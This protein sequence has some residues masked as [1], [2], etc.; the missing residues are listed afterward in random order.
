MKNFKDSSIYHILAVSGTHVGYIIIGLTYLLNRKNGSKR[1]IKAITAIFLII[2][3]AIS[4]FTASVVRACI[5]SIMLLL[6][7]IVYRKNDIW[8]SMCFSLLIILIS[9]PYNIRNNGVLLS[10]GGTIGIVYFLNN[11]KESKTLTS[12]T[13]KEKVIRYIKNT[14]LVSFSAQIILIPIIIYNYKTISLTF[15]ITNILTSY[16]IGIIIIFGFLLII[17]SF[18]FLKIA[19]I[20]GNIYKPIIDLLEFI[21]KNTAKLPFS[22]IYIKLPYIWEIIIYYILIFLFSYLYKKFREKLD[23][24]KAKKCI[25]TNHCSNFNYYSNI[26][27]L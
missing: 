16:I 10:F 13:Y 18:P 9:N 20:I 23:F 27:I 17:I 14:C 4:N 3:M 8:S 1:K 22:K 19:K 7:G 2:F 25:Q 6:S 24:A 21:T 5:M 26:W 12:N 15:L 11:K